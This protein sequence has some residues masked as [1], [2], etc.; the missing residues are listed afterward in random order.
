M[1]HRTFSLSSG[2]HSFS[3][4]S[5]TYLIF[6]PW[7]FRFGYGKC[8]VLNFCHHYILRI[9]YPKPGEEAGKMDISATVSNIS[10]SRGRWD[11]S[12]MNPSIV[13]KH[14]FTIELQPTASRACLSSA[15]LAVVQGASSRLWQIIVLWKREHRCPSRR[16]YPLYFVA[17]IK[18]GAENWMTL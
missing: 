11:G 5:S 2:V 12:L 17:L 15:N 7:D 4:T 14:I 13:K 10:W 8:E 1:T 6:S 16:G 18:M 9:L 3:L